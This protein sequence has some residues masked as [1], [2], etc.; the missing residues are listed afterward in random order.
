M[1]L[2]F[3]CGDDPWGEDMS[4]P[5]NSVATLGTHHHLTTEL[6]HGPGNRGQKV[7][8][9]TNKYDIIF[10]FSHKHTYRKR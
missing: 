8:K 1:I 2:T 7:F 10:L 9:H 6:G 3:R 5:Q 4:S